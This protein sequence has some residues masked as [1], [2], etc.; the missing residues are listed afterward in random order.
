MLFADARSSR[1][2]ALA[3]VS[4][5]ICAFGVAG[6]SLWQHMLEGMRVGNP[7]GHFGFR[8]AAR[9]YLELPVRGCA[10]R[11]CNVGFLDGHRLQH[12]ANRDASPCADSD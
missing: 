9:N 4:V 8:A 7:G 12:R 6:F 11:W 1:I 2:I 5:S 3:L 10:I